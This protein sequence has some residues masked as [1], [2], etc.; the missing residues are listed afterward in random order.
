ML[1][2]GK[3]VFKN[4]KKLKK[5][6]RD[7]VKLKAKKSFYLLMAVSLA[8]GSMPMDMVYADST[9][10]ASINDS[11]NGEQSEDSN[12]ANL[13]GNAENSSSLEQ[14]G[15]Q[16]DSGEEQGTETGN[17]RDEE[18]GI[19]QEEYEEE[20]S[21]AD[22][23][24]EKETGTGQEE[25][26]QSGS[27]IKQE[28]GTDNSH[29]EESDSDI[30][31]ITESETEEIKTTEIATE[32]ESEEVMI[33]LGM[34]LEMS[35]KYLFYDGIEC[36]AEVTD[37]SLDPKT[38][39]YYIS[40][41]VRMDEQSGR[42]PQSAYYEIKTDSGSL[43]GEL[44]FH[45]R[46]FGIYA[47]STAEIEKF[48]NYT[49]DVYASG[50]EYDESGK[51]G[52]KE[53]NDK[54]ICDTNVSVE[55][56]SK[57]YFGGNEKVTLKEQS[58]KVSD[59][60]E[61]YIQKLD[62]TFSGY[63]DSAVNS[64][65]EGVQVEL[66]VSGIDT[67]YS[68]MIP[69]TFYENGTQTVEL[70]ITKPCNYEITAKARGCE[71]DPTKG[72]LYKDCIINLNTDATD[73]KMATPTPEEL[74]QTIKIKED[75][76]KVLE[77]S[78]G[79]VITYQELENAIAK[80][81]LDEEEETECPGSIEIRESE[82]KSAL[83]STDKGFRASKVNTDKKDICAE[84]EIFL[85]HKAT[86]FCAASEPEKITVK[87]KKVPLNVKLVA[88]QDVKLCDKMEYSLQIEAADSGYEDLL[89]TQDINNFTAHYQSCLVSENGKNDQMLNLG[90][91][92][93][94]KPDE[95]HKNNAICNSSSSFVNRRNF[96]DC[97]AGN[98]YQLYAD[99]KYDTESGSPYIFPE[100]VAADNTIQIKKQNAV[101][102][103]S[104]DR[105]SA[106]FVSYDYREKY[107]SECSLKIVMKPT[108]LW[109]DDELDDYDKKEVTYEI[110]VQ[111]SDSNHPTV[112]LS[113][114]TDGTGTVQ[115]TY[116]EG[117]SGIPVKIKSP[118][119]ATITVQ[120]VGNRNYSTKESSFTVTVDNS[121]L[122]DS[123][124]EITY[125]E[126][127][128]DGGRY[129]TFTN[130]E[131]NKYLLEHDNW[132]RGQVKVSVRN[133]K[134]YNKIGCQTA[135]N[136]SEDNDSFILEDDSGVTSYSY[137]ALND[138]TGASTRYSESG[139][140][141]FTAG[142]DNTAPVHDENSF[143]NDNECYA[144]AST[145][146]K[147]YYDND[148]EISGIFYDETS[149]VAKIEYTTDADKGDK[150]VWKEITD[151]EA[152]K[153]DG[154][155]SYKLK[156]RQG[157]YTGI[158]LRA[159]D[160]AGN[161]SAQKEIKT[162]DG[163][164]IQ[165]VVDKEA[166][167]LDIKAQVQENAYEGEWTSKPVEY[168]VSAKEDS[169]TQLSGIY[170]YQYQFVKIGGFYSDNDDAW[171]DIT[172]GNRLV[173]GA[174]RTDE[175]DS[176]S[177]GI[178]A[179]NRN[180]TYYFRAITKSGVKTTIEE[181][182]ADS[183]RI[184][185]WQTLP[186]KCEIVQTGGDGERKNEWYNKASGVPK[187]YFNYP[188][189]DNGV[190]NKEYGAP[191]TVH[192]RLRVTTEEGTSTLGDRT[193]TIGIMCDDD[194][195]SQSIIKEDL[196][197]ILIDFDYDKSTGYARDGIYKLE[198][199]ISDA[200]GNESEHD[201]YEYKIDTHEPTDIV[202]M[203]D[204]TD[205][206]TDSNETIY[207]EHFYK[208][209]VSGRASADYGISGK[210]SLKLLRAKQIGDWNNNKG[211]IQ[212]DTDSFT[213]PACTRCFVYAVAEDEAGNTSQAWTRGIVV[214]DKAPMEGE[215]DSLVLNPK[216]A[217]KNG[218]YNKDIP[219][220]ISI[221]DSP[222]EDDYSSLQSIKYTVG[223]E[224]KET[225]SGQEI[226][227]FTKELPTQEELTGASSLKTTQLISAAENESN[228]SY[229]EVTATD[230]SGNTNTFTRQLK[231][232]VTSPVTDISFDNMDSQNG[233]YFKAD[234]TAKI[235]VHELNFDPEYV[236]VNITRNGKPYKAELS[237]WSHDGLEHYA[238]VSF[239]EDGD[240]TMTVNCKDQ[241]DNKAESVTA[242][243]FTVDKTAPVHVEE[244]FENNN[245]CYEPASSSTI[246]Y[247]NKDYVI[248]G[249]FFDET[250][251]VR[252]IQY[253]TDADTENPQ[254]HDVPIMSQGDVSE[255]MK[256][257][258]TFGHGIYTGIAFRAIDASGNISDI[259]GITDENGKYI[260][261][262][263]DETQ[264][265]INVTANTENRDE[266][267][268]EW[269]NK[270]IDCTIIDVTDKNIFLAGIFKYQYQYVKIGE[271]YSEADSAWEDAPQDLIVRLGVK[272]I[273]QEDMNF[274]DKN[275]T[276]YFRAI[277]RSGVVTALNNQPHERI[278][279]QQTLSDRK[280]LSITE[281]DVT[282]KNEWYNKESGVPKIEFVYPEYDSGVTS[283]RYDAPV[284]I[285]TILTATMEEG[286]K[287]FG[288]K[289][290]TIGIMSDEDYAKQVVTQTNIGELAI[291]FG[292]DGASGYAEDGIY[293]LE[294]WITDEAGNESAHDTYEYKID[295]HEPTNLTI[296]IDGNDM[297]AEPGSAIRY[298]KFSQTELGGKAGAEYGISGKDTLKIYKEKRTGDWKEDGDFTQNDSDSFS[299]SACY[300]GFI[301]TLAE[302]VAGNK[303]EIYSR[304]VVVDDKAPTGITNAELVLTP[305]GA[306]E[307]GF[308]NDDIEVK[309][310][311][312]DE[313][314]D[315]NFSALETV[316]CVV[317]KQEND[318]GSN[319]E[320]FSFTTPQPTEE[321][322]N[323]AGTFETVEV[324]DAAANESN[325]AYIEV[326]AVDRCGN[327][328][329]SKE[330]LKIDVTK[331]VI[332]ITFDNENVTNE[333]Y[334]NADRTA[335][336]HISEL[337]FDP[338][339][340]KIEATRDGESYPVT[341]S[342]WRN[343]ESEHYA[344]VH[345]TQDGDYTMSVVCTD[346]ADNEADK[347]E[348][349][350]F[351][352][353]KTQPVVEISY[354]NERAYKQNYYAEG[355]TATIAVTE[356]N[357]SEKDFILNA[358][359]AVSLGSWTH[360]GDIH[361]ARI[362]FS[363]DGHYTWSIE[364]KDLAGNATSPM[365]ME[366]FYID[367]EAPAV[368]ISGV[369]NGS[370]NSGEVTPV[371]TVIDESFDSEG[372]A[373]TITTGRGESV[374][375]VRSAASVE[376]GYS[377]TLTD[378]TKRE[379]DIYYLTAIGTDLAGNQTSLTYRFSL[380]RH[381]STY[382]LT[383]ISD[384]VSGTYY[385]HD[386]ITDMKIVE[387]N[388]DTVEEFGIY[389]SRNGE[390]LKAKKVKS[391]P[392]N[393]ASDEI[394]YSV[395]SSG[396]ADL[397]YTYTYTLYKENFENEGLY[398]ISFYSRDRAGNEVN[399]TLDEKGAEIHF[400][401]DDT[402]P[403]VVIEGIDSNE[404]YASKQQNVNVM[405]DDN[406]K[407]KEAWFYLVNED[408]EETGR[409]NYMELA[410]Q[411]GEVVTITVPGSDSKQTFL[412][413][414]CD[415]AGNEVTA[416]PDSEEVP[417]DFLITTNKWKRLENSKP[418]RAVAASAAV[419]GAITAVVAVF[420]RKIKR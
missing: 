52:Y 63:N 90:N 308:Y 263:V 217:N 243:E 145:A 199:W 126:N 254:W 42:L 182:K 94:F 409:W 26:I 351:T 223:S 109:Y 267:K 271:S 264:P 40:F 367:T 55:A 140:N 362:S 295:T 400:V 110:K 413:S 155:T 167:E 59:D 176:S 293:T 281:S 64:T 213:I 358:E 357:F 137:W 29:S 61:T 181:Q 141:S 2:K 317:G 359:P 211:F 187:I 296:D 119:T 56:P 99:I 416:L 38:G 198:Y 11:D 285:H 365:E 123:D 300:R 346:M 130:K 9:E 194:Y 207:Y 174:G 268:G 86:T 209:E 35:E 301:Y 204:E 121:S 115:Y 347:A 125:Y 395:Q 216:G 101:M 186:D 251:K 74:K 283:K 147:Q 127:G 327:I 80:T 239:T 303:A 249:E 179:Q 151:I 22:K 160:N 258:C 202:I 164:Y 200:A 206:C 131:W 352:L 225:V 136:V 138:I 396:N 8:S 189:Y 348:I 384:I 53:V 324:I 103:L 69:L 165:I 95:D 282:R 245:E 133:N 48:G 399:N 118:G 30:E 408:G 13:G 106:D 418:A 262:I 276:Y 257:S 250:S 197:N 238:T 184:R 253:T 98:A 236:S 178:T 280:E 97:R 14:G 256:Y 43:S 311:V 234:R 391:R 28:G 401:I 364:G 288:E 166:P 411:S 218:F 380:N 397:G 23:E 50:N 143:K 93:T 233:K 171:T 371:I 51:N 224:G 18:Q 342:D 344:T 322:L 237:S 289:T 318:A 393:V 402:A 334:Y 420:K 73:C 142:I 170:K 89:K 244:S 302:D 70:H 350:P 37:I 398:T 66:E 91:E 255:K 265:L 192:T 163:R 266:Y 183:K 134:Y 158:A 161:V 210:G 114:D 169:G 152:G 377:Y 315:D 341:I 252:S 57:Y 31:G 39:K 231:I 321:E 214:D 139:K 58:G 297:T 116:Y 378:F 414:A 343:E 173:I 25:S 355:R 228:F 361:T 272:G 5:E 122:T 117:Q 286:D 215:T 279:L 376:N 388:V 227:N 17:S 27:D 345:F 177:T 19:K 369:E 287:D 292:Y 33:D 172:N 412:Y 124:Y 219:V 241:A 316:S 356:H 330:E 24:G 329:T 307:N 394:C 21:G 1:Y 404:I 190:I 81:Y 67:D 191:I 36:E 323:A 16:N 87:V 270:E 274:S 259:K 102:E 159:T 49:I 290:A 232:D 331:P 373:I 62:I 107:D 230:R 72:S 332:D 240:Y 319:K 201:T 6:L 392:E 269:T 4:M 390:L 403:Q 32:E 132:I 328:K 417:K 79:S 415:A 144:A 208:K 339:K 34:A 108:S 15:T 196:N 261:I 188:E 304:G 65:A 10:S 306:N 247:F 222:Y 113:R 360:N 96:E 150:A 60:G 111:N 153:E 235:H 419:I 195:K 212:N 336:I 277:S 246:Q 368:T 326:T 20:G 12:N 338:A 180:G 156:L 407:L 248:S 226:F 242:P 386:N 105:E 185:L 312:R 82:D 75:F 405:V 88:P 284:T 168:I 157:S 375:V 372:V 381:G 7:G 410:K 333:K 305:D 203:V 340:V 353:D 291:D 320:L 387:M 76:P 366:D 385:R 229:I 273:E 45:E 310:Q 92:T 149:R 370:A 335:T 337:N 294:Y 374:P 221:K 41:E 47:S 148:Y 193:A 84:T 100:R 260:K 154:Q 77:I 299:I 383:N 146:T 78:Y 389:I 309:I 220:E 313:P 112:E 175:Q 46:M 120:E 314:L 128:L 162:D 83:S 129:R 85:Y 406:F 135:G 205:M 44:D 71:A 298:E 104:L 349:E 54:H 278:R 325:F 382:D 68:E 354:D 363:G 3:V 379:D 275:G